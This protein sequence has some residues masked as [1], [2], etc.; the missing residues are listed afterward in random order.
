MTGDSRP[1]ARLWSRDFILAFG[2]NAFSMM[3]FYLLLTS[4]ALYAA[5]RFQASDSA[6]G[7]ASSA[8]IIGSILARLFAG[9]LLDV[10]GRKRMLMVS[11]A[12]FVV[13]SLLYIPAETLPGLIGLRFLHGVA[14]GAGNTALG[15]SVQAII[16]PA[17]RSEGTGYYGLSATLATATGPFLAVSLSSSGNYTAIFYASAAFSVASFVIALML[18]MPRR[19]Q[20]TRPA[21]GQ[22]GLRQGGLRQGGLRQGRFLASLV[23]RTVLPVT[24]VILLT[25]VGY[26]GVVAFLASYAD[27]RG[28]ANAASGF[29]LTYAVAVAFSRLFMGRL[30]D[31]HGDNAVIYPAL[32]AFAAG[33]GML[34]FPPS[35][36]TIAAAALLAGFG[37]STLMSGLQAIAVSK[38]PSTHI[39]TAVSTFYLVLD[40]GVGLGPVALGLLVPAAG[41]QGMYAACSALAVAAI[42]VYHL[43]HGRHQ[44]PPLR[45][46]GRPTP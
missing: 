31:R 2:A 23:E 32:A 43:V 1:P 33:V 19:P 38:V 20:R 9:R 11:L 15:A 39:G 21:A 35:P 5:E 16:P 8:Y 45:Q 24:M 22:P 28:V 44:G 29:F 12:A 6:A 40:V 30:Q 34:A 7:L 13:F 36:A 46:E 27:S 14:F 26:S 4:M 10:V 18:R 17:R 41:F 25:G 37:Y 3:V 42:G